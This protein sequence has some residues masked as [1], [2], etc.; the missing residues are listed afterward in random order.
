MLGVLLRIRD[1]FGTRIALDRLGYRSGC[2]AV[3]DIATIEPTSA[4]PANVGGSIVGAP[5]RG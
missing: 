4:E 3:G 2:V 5:Y 1:R